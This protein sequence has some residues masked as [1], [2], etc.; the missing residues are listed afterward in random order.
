MAI[1]SVKKPRNVRAVFNLFAELIVVL[2][3]IKLDAVAGSIQNY[4]EHHHNSHVCN[5]QHPKAHDVRHTIKS[6]YYYVRNVVWSLAF[7]LFL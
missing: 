6:K 2:F 4:I 5:H 3:V 1:N 7:H